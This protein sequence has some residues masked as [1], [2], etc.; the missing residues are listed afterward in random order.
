VIV[1]IKTGRLL[2]RHREDLRFYAL[3]ETLVRDVP[4]QLVASYSLDSAAAETEEV[5]VELLRSTLRRTLDGV[6][7]MV[8][9]RFE[10]RQP[11]RSPGPTCRWCPLR[12]ECDDGHAWL[13][14]A[15]RFSD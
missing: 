15:D 12:G 5:T 3:I 11:S 7:R 13:A 9:I 10:G 4:P 2:H 14:A 1:D 6:E 8:E